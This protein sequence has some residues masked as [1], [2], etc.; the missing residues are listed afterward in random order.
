MNTIKLT[1]TIVDPV[2]DSNINDDIN[3]ITNVIIE[4]ITLD[5]TTLLNFL[6]I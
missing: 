6:N 5:I 2:G 1:I 4:I 3:P